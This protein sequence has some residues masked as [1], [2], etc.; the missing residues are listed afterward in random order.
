MMVETFEAV[1]A[2]QW[3]RYLTGSIE[4]VSAVLLFVPGRQAIG[5]SLLT[6]TMIGAVVAHF[7]ILGPSAVPAIVLGVLA[8][9]VVWV[10]RDQIPVQ[11]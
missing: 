2:G 6:C 3:F 4:V 10:H 9:M 7:V 1:G 11:N 8:A 5:A